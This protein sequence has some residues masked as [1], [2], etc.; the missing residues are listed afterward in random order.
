VTVWTSVRCSKCG[1]EGSASPGVKA[2]TMRQELRAH[3]WLHEPSNGVDLCSTCAPL[4]GGKPI[5]K[6]LCK[7]EIR[8]TKVFFNETLV[9]CSS[10]MTV[11]ESFKHAPATEVTL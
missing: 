1:V 9:V 2:H 5:R 4:G 11:V 8:Q 10:C 6:P 7:H 3:G